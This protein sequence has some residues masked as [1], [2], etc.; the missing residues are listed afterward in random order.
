M[1]KTYEIVDA[2]VNHPEAGEI[3]KQNIVYYDENGRIETVESYSNRGVVAGSIRPGY[4]PKTPETPVE[5]IDISKI[6]IDS[7][8]DEQVLKLKE[9]INKL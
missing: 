1:N 2:T 8:T 5:R 6:D 4:D 7:L 3:I 9:R